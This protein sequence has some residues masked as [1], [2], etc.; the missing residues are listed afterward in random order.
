[1][2][3]FF[4]SSG[5]LAIGA[6]NFLRAVSL[7]M[8][9][10]AGTLPTVAVAQIEQLSA[11]QRRML[12]QLPPAQRQQAL[13][14]IR[15]IQANP[16]VTTNPPSSLNEQLSG[17]PM[18]TNSTGEVLSD[19]AAAAEPVRADRGSR[20]IIDFAPR[21]DLSTADQRLLENDPALSQLGGSGY[22]E[23]DSAGVLDLA[24][25]GSIPLLGLTTDQIEL[26]LAAEPALRIFEVSATILD[27][28]EFGTAALKPY[29]Y[30]VFETDGS[31]FGP[32]TSGPVPP[33]HVLGPGDSVRVQLFGN[34][35]GIYEFEVTREGILNLPE[36]GPITVAGLPFSEF[37]QDLRDRVQQMLIG[38]QVSVTLGQLRTI[39]VFVLGDANRPGSYVVTS[40]ATISSALYVAGGVSRI[41]SL[42]DIQLK[43]DGD[44]IASLDL[45]DLLLNGDTSG[46]LRLQPGDVIFIPPVNAQVSVNGAVR[47]PAIY[48]L[49]GET[50]ITEVVRLAGGM[51]PE[52]FPEESR[53]ERIG[54]DRER[55]VVSVD[56]ASA[57]ADSTTA[58]AGDVIF[59]PR[60]LP[61]FEDTVQVS[62]FVQRPGPYEWRPGMRLTDVLGSGLE[63]KPGADAEYLLV[64]R[65]DPTDRQVH[66][67]STSLR[68][69][70]AAPG[71]EADI[72]LQPRDQVFVFSRAYGRQR[73]IEPLL[74]ELELQARYGRPNP[75]VSITG[76]VRAPGN[77]PLE[78]D[79]RLSDLIRA[80]G[81]LT[82]AA[83]AVKAELVRYS[84]IGDEYRTTDVLDVDLNAVL[85]GD[86]AADLPLV[87]YDNVRI[88]RLPEWNTSWTVELEGEVKFPGQYRVRRGET[89][90]EVLNRAGGLTDAA[91]PEG[92]VFL[93]ESLRLQE[94]EQ[95]DLLAQRLQADLTSLSLQ[96]A[97]TTGTQTLATGRELLTQLRS[98]EAVGRLVIDLNSLDPEKVDVGGLELRDGDQLMIP[99]EPQSVT[100][101]G[102]TQQNTSHIYEPGLSRE[103]YIA[104]SGG[105]T[106]RADKKLI[107][108]VR[109]SGAVQAGNR[110]R[111]FGRG[112]SQGAEMRPGDTI[113]VPLETDKIRPLTFW[114][115]VTQILY[116]AAIAV[117]AIET[118]N[119]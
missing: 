71:S 112:S 55:V 50:S 111:W 105:L 85:R 91:F 2:A 67:V 52:A 30:D 33:D 18:V 15:Q 11:E 107:Y 100:V 84:V 77:Y 113:V 47:R 87:E 36:L 37:R 98:V 1:M 70:V 28:A 42:R 83:Y 74:Q 110:S 14:A 6:A 102:E 116:Q 109:A 16:G 17:A 68:D 78:P 106:R 58:R 22:F 108:V 46:D 81:D 94:Q 8:V 39:R 25:I 44:L 75:V 57:S 12:N 4:D 9:L 21:D 60:V 40:L 54:R 119:N 90:S 93:R 34:V 62:G 43:R 64:R 66:V 114:T 5:K 115:Q 65:E 61:E 26:R 10:F 82:D 76:S 97:D 104:M 20:L 27:S 45:Y 13:D 32:V 31:I 3:I 95:I 99:K 41:G 89:L 80:G 72:E 51:L 29:G 92:A 117:A 59:V 101:I 96:N 88:S 79:M 118:F 24:G 73:L 103:D 63:L 38:T 53:I 56:A 7:I 35:N 86:A 69:A 48:E 19:L 49:S 23:I